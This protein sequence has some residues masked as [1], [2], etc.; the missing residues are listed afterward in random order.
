MEGKKEYTNTFTLQVQRISGLTHKL[1]YLPL[2]FIFKRKFN[3]T[4]SKI[5]VF[6]LLAH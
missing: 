1:K 2:R 4:D 3:G 5:Q 6:S